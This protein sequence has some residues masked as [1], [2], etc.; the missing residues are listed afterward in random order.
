MFVRSRLRRNTKNH[1]TWTPIY[2]RFHEKIVKSG[3]N[4]IYFKFLS[5][6]VK[7]KI[8]NILMH[9]L[10]IIF[11]KILFSYYFNHDESYHNLLI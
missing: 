3:K 10:E 11:S 7:Y 2:F 5:I 8:K 4:V 6:F 9:F 1:K